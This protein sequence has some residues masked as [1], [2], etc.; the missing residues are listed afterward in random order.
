MTSLDLGSLTTVGHNLD[1]SYNYEMTTLDLGS[2]SLVEGAFDIY[3][4]PELC[5]DLVDQ[6]YSSTTVLGGS[7]YLENYGDCP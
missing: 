4:N 1:I 5:Q 3:L 2:L 7:Y 6:V